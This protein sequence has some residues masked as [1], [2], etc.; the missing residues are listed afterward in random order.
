MNEERDDDGDAI[1][2][3]ADDIAALQDEQAALSDEL[4][5]SGK[6]KWR[7]LQRQLHHIGKEL[8]AGRRLPIEDE[9]DPGERYSYEISPRRP[10]LGGGWRLRLLDHGQ[11][12]GGGA[13][14]VVPDGSAAEWWNSLGDGDR[15]AW[16]NRAA[17]STVEGAY[18][19]YLN[20]GAYQDAVG[21]A[22]EWL[23]SRA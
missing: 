14:P 17:E 7:E 10:E 8:A 13:F 5:E 16:R 1:E 12:V 20:D 9:Y 22:N 6:A 19:A 21:T 4:P 11:E 2:L 3:T 18:H 15:S 23:H